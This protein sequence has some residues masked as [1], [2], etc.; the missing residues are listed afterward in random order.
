MDKTLSLA[1]D[2]VKAAQDAT[3]VADEREAVESAVR[4]FVA[5]K[6]KKTPLEGMLELVGKIHIRDDY[7]YKAMRSG[8]T[9]E[10]RS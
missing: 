8:G 7:D 2:V 5:A 1:D 10:D 3:G 4:A 9:D 6:Q